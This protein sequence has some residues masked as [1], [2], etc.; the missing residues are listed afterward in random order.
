MTETTADIPSYSLYST[1]N[2][3]PV[4]MGQTDYEKNKIAE[5]NELLHSWCRDETV[6]STQFITFWELFY[7]IYFKF[8]KGTEYEKDL[9]VRLYQ[10]TVEGQNKCFTGRIARMVNVLVG[11][12]P[13]IKLNFADSD[14]ISAKINLAKEK[15]VE[16]FGDLSYDDQ[17]EKFK[18]LV[19]ELLREINVDDQMI[20]EWLE[21][22]EF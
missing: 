21:N 7:K 5:M 13:E 6:H 22:F 1:Y 9:L 16:Q 18:S 3:I 15:T 20:E 19:Y 2:F 12:Y 4:E 17:Y 14:Q 11:F 10:E 8:I